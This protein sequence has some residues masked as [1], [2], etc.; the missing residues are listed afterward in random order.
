VLVGKTYLY[1]KFRT[2]SLMMDE[3]MV[4][5]FNIIKSTVDLLEVSK[6]HL[7]K[8]GLAESSGPLLTVE[9]VI[10][11]LRDAITNSNGICKLCGHSYNHNKDDGDLSKKLSSFATTTIASQ[12]DVLMRKKSRPQLVAQLSNI[13]NFSNKSGHAGD[14]SDSNSEAPSL[15]NF[16]RVPSSGNLKQAASSSGLASLS[17]A[18]S[19]GVRTYGRGTS[20]REMESFNEKPVEVPELTNDENY[21]MK[22]K[23]QEAFMILDKDH[24]GTLD[25]IYIYIF[26]L[27]I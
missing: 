5:A 23:A 4:T 7:L 16:S 9:S 10:T 22:V 1:S 24:S 18:P 27:Y 3:E 19:L 13:S 25:G 14:D 17:R 26:E 21:I 11:E 20:L 6:T 2:M 8:S 12:R 15:S